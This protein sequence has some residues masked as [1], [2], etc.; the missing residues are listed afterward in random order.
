MAAFIREVVERELNRQE[1]AKEPG[2][3]HQKR[4]Q[5]PI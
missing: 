4:L 1:K 5:P 2:E 3:G